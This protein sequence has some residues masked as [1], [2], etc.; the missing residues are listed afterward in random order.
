M[1]KGILIFA[2]IELKKSVFHKCKYPADTKEIN[3]KKY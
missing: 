2:D 1:S 3:I